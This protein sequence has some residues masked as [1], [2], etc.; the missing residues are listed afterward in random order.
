MQ[1]M[2]EEEEGD[3]PVE[4]TMSHLRTNATIEQIQE[5]NDEE[6][7]F[8]GEVFNSPEAQRP[9]WFSCRREIVTEMESQS[10][11]DEVVSDL[12]DKLLLRHIFLLIIV[13][14]SFRPV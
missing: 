10:S 4:V 2:E 11:E 5:E 13:C 12:I 7:T 8:H 1:Q 14:E 3:I 9:P 6:H